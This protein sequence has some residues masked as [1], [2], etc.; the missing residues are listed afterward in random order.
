MSAER[1]ERLSR[2]TKFFYGAGDIGFSL[3]GALI[4]ILFAIFLMDVVG[5]RPAR[6]VER[7]QGT[8][9]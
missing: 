7:K 9:G 8:S 6:A 3:T 5:I 1:S 4:A 2:R